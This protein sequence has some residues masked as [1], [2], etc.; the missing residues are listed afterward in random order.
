MTQR[1]AKGQIQAPDL[2]GHKFGWLTV[3]RR[4]GTTPRQAALWLCRCACPAG[5]EKEVTTS[6]LNNGTVTSCGCKKRIRYM[7]YRKKTFQGDGKSVLL[8]RDFDW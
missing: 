4:T 2:T 5:T 7:G 6:A 3:I 1:N 8:D